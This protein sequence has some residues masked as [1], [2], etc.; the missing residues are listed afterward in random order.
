MSDN[1]L[2]EAQSKILRA[3]TAGQ[4][5]RLGLCADDR[6]VRDEKITSY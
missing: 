2:Y 4:G 5:G 3:E 1:V 6:Y